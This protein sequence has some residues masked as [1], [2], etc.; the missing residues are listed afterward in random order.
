MSFLKQRTLSAGVLIVGFLFTCSIM[1]PVVGLSKPNA[2]DLPS[3]LLSPSSSHFFGTDGFGRDIF[4]RCLYAVRLDLFVCAVIT[5]VPMIFG[6]VAGSISGYFGG[7]FDTIMSRFIEMLLAFPFLILVIAVVAI[8]GPGLTGVFV[9]VLAIGWTLYA[10][11][12]RAEMLVIRDQ[13]FVLAAKTLGFSTTRI[14]FRHAMPSLLRSNVVFSMSDF[15]SNLLLLAGLSYLGLGVQ[16]PTAEL[17]SM[18]AEGQQ[19]LSQAWWIAV[20]PGAIVVLLGSGLSMIG[21]GSA[22]RMT[23]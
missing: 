8:S 23:V 5:F 9:A 11:I 22:D 17:G 15:V 7:W 18:I 13:E 14:I 20:V 4:T 19:Y 2:I 12:S 21:D 3:R 6:V 10:R 1:L 16:A